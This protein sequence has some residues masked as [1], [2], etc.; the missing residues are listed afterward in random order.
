MTEIAVPDPHAVV[1]QTGRWTYRVYVADGI[2]QWGPDGYGWIVW[3]RR[4]AE[5][6]GRKVLA[7]Y[8]REQAERVERRAAA[9]IV[10]REDLGEHL[11]AA[12]H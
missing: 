11:R 9:A 12:D 1:L 6:K 3:G 10:Y 2:S 5:R 4:R 7:R 8:L